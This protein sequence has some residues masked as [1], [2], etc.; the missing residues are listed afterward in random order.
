MKISF[1]DQSLQT[2]FEYPS[3]SSLAQ[4]EEEEDEEEREDEEEDDEAGSGL[5]EKPFALFLPR[6]TLVSS[7]V[8]E[9]P[10]LPDGGSG[11]CPPAPVG[12]R[13][14]EPSHVPTCPPLPPGL[15]S[16]TP[17]H[18]VAFSKWQEQMLEPVAVREAEPPPQEVTVS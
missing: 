11:G 6:A 5:E 9:S 14:G 1:N 17:K 2:T 15:S 12:A 18:C 16:Y 8:P 4:D 10:R 13:S 3:E 7:V